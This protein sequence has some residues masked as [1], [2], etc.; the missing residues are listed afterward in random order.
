[1][2]EISR[3]YG[4]VIYMY[5]NDHGVAHFHVK[6][7]EYEVAIEVES[8]LVHGELPGRI[9]SNALVW[10]RLHRA[11]L[12][13]NWRRARGNMPLHRIDPLG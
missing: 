1:M 13:E 4:L 12:L 6:S 2:P 10:A 9:L 8:E 11:E 7:A 3:F 5:H